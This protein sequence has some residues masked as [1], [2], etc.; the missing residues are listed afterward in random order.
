MPA[1][2][3]DVRS[4]DAFRSPAVSVEQQLIAALPRNL[5]DETLEEERLS[6]FTSQ[7]KARIE[8]EEKLAH[9]AVSNGSQLKEERSELQIRA[10]HLVEAI[11]QHGISSLR[12]NFRR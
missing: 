4:G 5:L 9:E 12:H 10:G 2:F 3:R 8:L 7:L 1:R 11:E 6:E